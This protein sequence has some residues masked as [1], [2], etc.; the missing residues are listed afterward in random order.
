MF[1]FESLYVRKSG[2]KKPH[3]RKGGIK[4]V[5]SLQETIKGCLTLSTDG[6]GV[7]T[8]A[9]AAFCDSCCSYSALKFAGIILKGLPE[10][11]LPSLNL[12]NERKCVI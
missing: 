12:G 7:Q 2:K 11:V 8:Y 4:T 5:S 10:V 9:H 3:V 1:V 6:K